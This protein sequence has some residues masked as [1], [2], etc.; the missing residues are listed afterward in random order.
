VRK[1]RNILAGAAVVGSLAGSLA[2]ASAANAATAG[3]ET[4][5]ATAAAQPRFHN[6][7]YY[8]GYS[9]GDGESRSDRS[10]FRGYWYKQSGFY[11]VR[12]ELFDRDH[13]RQ[14]SYFHYRYIDRFGNRHE[15]QFKTFDHDNYNKKFFHAK[16]FWVGVSEGGNS[17]DDFGGYHQLW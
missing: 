13:D 11:Y 12:G 15:G 5:S 4:T 3:A 7:I 6:F 17:R 14:Y 8:S 9:R 10:Y 16:H 1:I 2:L